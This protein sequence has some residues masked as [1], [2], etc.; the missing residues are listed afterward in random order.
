MLLNLTL[1]LRASYVELSLREEQCA[2]TVAEAAAPLRTAAASMLE[3]E[4]A[5]TFAPKEAL[6]NIVRDLGRFGDLLPH[7]SEARERR[8]LPGGRAAE[9]LFETYELARALHERAHRIE[10]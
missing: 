6:Q 4:G 2:V 9:T 10:P 7:L 5:G 3:L 1:R 8:V